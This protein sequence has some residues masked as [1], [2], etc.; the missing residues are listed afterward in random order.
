PPLTATGS[1]WDRCDTKPCRLTVPFESWACT[2]AQRLAGLATGASHC[3][4]PIAERPPD[5]P[6]VAEWVHDAAQQPAM[7]FGHPARCL[8]AGP[9]CG[10]RHRLRIVDNEQ[11]SARRSTD[12]RGIEPTHLLGR[13]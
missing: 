6:L 3:W 10:V 2:R 4:R 7:L 12:R 11:D 5:L 1:L 9:D 13:P 8:G